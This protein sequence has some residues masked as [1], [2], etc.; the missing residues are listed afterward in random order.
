MTTPAAPSLTSL[1]AGSWHF[2]V[3]S[4]LAEKVSSC[5]PGSEWPLSHL[6]VDNRQIHSSAATSVHRATLIDDGDA[7]PVY[8]KHFHFRSPLD[9]LK[10]WVKKSRAM[11]AVAGD[12]LLQRHGFMAPKPLIAGWQQQRGK[13]TNYFTVAT[14]LE[15][16]RNIYQTI[17]SVNQ[18]GG[19]EK[20]TFIKALATT[21]ADLHRAQISHGDMRAGNV[22]CLQDGETG[23]WQFA[24]IDNERTR[25]HRYLPESQRIKN[26]VQLNLLSSPALDTEDRQ[27][28]Y[29]I[30]SARCFGVLNQQLR[31]KVITKTRRRQAK[32]QAKIRQAN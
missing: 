27:F 18:R 15:G 4:T 9:H 16:Y 26:L 17:E 3:I 19:S 7:T 21:V 14:A 11:R 6:L 20:N 23:H 1:R 24:F 22:L 2:L 13:K 30:Y 10:H 29:E 5:E 31:Q 25:Q 32:K 8:V 28:F 12:M